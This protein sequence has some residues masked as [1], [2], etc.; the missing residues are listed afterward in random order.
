MSKPA[1]IVDEVTVHP[2]DGYGTLAYL[3]ARNDVLTDRVAL[4]GSSN[5]ARATLPACPRPHRRSNRRHRPR[6]FK[7]IIP[8]ECNDLDEKSVPRT[9]I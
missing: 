9:A 3:R 8:Q 6:A 4:Q 2:L 5:D 7:E 1:R